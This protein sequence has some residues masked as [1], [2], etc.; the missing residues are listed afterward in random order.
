MTL[1][2]TK[3]KL[4]AQNIFTRYIYRKF[5]FREYK[6]KVSDFGRNE[7]KKRARAAESSFESSRV[8]YK[9]TPKD[10]SD[11]SISKDKGT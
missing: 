8:M 10:L 9:R 5:K 1:R 6:Q 7:I 11:F 3:P 4:L 2:P